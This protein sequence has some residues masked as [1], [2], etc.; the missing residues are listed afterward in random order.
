MNVLLLGSGGREHTLAWKMAQS[1]LLKQLFTCPG[2]A[3]T[4]E[5]G[6][7]VDIDYQNMS[8]LKSFLLSEKIDMVVVGPEVPL[9]NG[10]HNEI[11][12]DP[13]ISHIAVIGPKKEGAQLE[14]SK[15]FA[16]R[17]MNKYH[18]PTAHHKTF[19]KKSINDGIEFLKDIKSPYVLKADGLA[20]GKGVLIL[21]DLD[22]AIEAFKDILL[23]DKFGSAGNQVVIEEFL[24][25]VELSVFVLTDG[26]SY[27][28]LPEAKDYK[29]IGEGDTGPNTGG[30]GSVSPV[31][32]ADEKFLNLV[33]ERI[34]EPTIYGLQNEK[35]DYQGF[36]FFGLI[37]VK[38]H[39]YVIEYNVRMGDPETESV[40][41]R[42]KTDLL[43]LFVAMS[44]QR[45]HNF[46]IEIS[47]K[48]AVSVMLVSK[49]YPDA[50]E[51]GKLI[52]GCDGAENTMLFHAGTKATPH[53]VVTDGGRVMAITSL[54]D[55][56]EEA[57]AQVFSMAETIHFDGKYYRRDIGFDI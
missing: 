51:K 37:N 18:I 20:S 43:E 15:D 22:E 6:K 12:N 31:P 5:V 7:N 33:K 35:I 19:D 34:I 24:S 4:M 52:S 47:P 10:I 56:R 3:G 9:V 27:V 45:L 2:N 14:G 13:E 8:Q 16:K 55:T 25:G 11:A 40:M 36:I 1:P 42:L 57:L 38:G 23:S 53:G 54:S 46:P 48:T 41:P 28:L 21:E 17:F 39:P 29:R 30:M 49:G 50:Y 26:K 32:F 44:E